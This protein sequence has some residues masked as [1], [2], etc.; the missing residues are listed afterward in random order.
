MNLALTEDQGLLAKTAADFVAERSPVA[1]VRKLRDEKT[2]PGFSRDLWREMAGLGWVGIPFPEWAGGAGMGLADL[3]VVLEAL[4]RGLAPEPFLSSVLLGGQ[5]VLLGG[6]DAQRKAVLPAL[7]SGDRLLALAFQEDGSRYDLNRIVT[8]AEA[9]DAGWRISGR[10]IQVLDAGAADQ[11]VVAARTA[12]G[13]RDSVGISLFL[14]SAKIP[15]LRVR[16]QQR[17][18]SRS[19]AMVE[20]ESVVAGHDDVLGEPGSGGA[21][22]EQVVDRAT[23]GVCAEMLGL[24]TEAFERTL[25]YLKTRV[26][27][28][29]PIGSFQALKHRAALCFIEIELSRSAVMAA[30]RAVDEDSPEAQQL[31]SAAKARCSDAAIRVTNEAVQMHGGIGMTDEHDIGFFMKRA[32]VAELTFGDAAWHRD[33]YARLEGY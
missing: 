31:V 20:L 21:L 16:P 3:A 30:A 32:R 19:A 2:P 33:R 26:Q 25:A 13:E 28:G 4:G 5:A 27:F 29:V 22:L 12:G 7:C 15:G 24:M 18:D 23:V 11:V 17:I 10:K 9:C 8:R 6:S 14:L 1:R